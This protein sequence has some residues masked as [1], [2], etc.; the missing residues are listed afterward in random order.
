MKYS[1]KL[2]QYFLPTLKE[3]PK[4]A[5]IPSHKLMIRA[6][7][8]RKLASGIYEILPLGWR[9]IKKIENIVREEMDKINGQEIMMSAMQPKSLWDLSGRWD[10]YGP[11]LLLLLQEIHRFP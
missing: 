6:G 5:E 9:V 8:I 10:L 4:E 7:M 2:S 1:K 11:E 3:N